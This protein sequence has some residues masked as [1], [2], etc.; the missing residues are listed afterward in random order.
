M[1]SSCP[2]QGSNLHALHFARWILKHWT[3]REVPSPSLK[4][5]FHYSLVQSLLMWWMAGYKRE[6]VVFIP[7]TPS[8][9]ISPG[10]KLLIGNRCFSFWGSRGSPPAHPQCCLTCL[11]RWTS[12]K[13]PTISVSLYLCPTGT[14][15]PWRWVEPSNVLLRNKIWKHDGIAFLRWGY[16]KIMTSVLLAFSFSLVEPLLW[17]EVGWYKLQVIP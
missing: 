13:S 6:W 10:D 4:T 12:E 17:R 8:S 11:S 7:F 1:G 9:I 15:P 5:S 2:N 3:T 14:S 16:T